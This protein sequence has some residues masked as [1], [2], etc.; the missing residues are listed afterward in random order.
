[1]KKMNRILV[2]TRFFLALT[3]SVVAM[4]ATEANGAWSD[5][6]DSYVDGSTII[7][8]GAWAQCHL[9]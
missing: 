5:N 6:F 4:A 9:L 3:T 1:M 2:V 8:Q 7:G